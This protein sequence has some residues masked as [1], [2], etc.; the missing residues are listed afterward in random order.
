MNKLKIFLLTII[1]TS[2]AV[3]PQ[4]SWID[5]PKEQWPAIAMINNVEYKNGE[6]YIHSSFEYAGTGFLVDTGSDTLAVTAKH[7]LWIAKTKSMNSVDLQGNLKKWIM[8]PKGN[9]KDSVVITKLINTDSSEILNGPKSTITERD[10]IVF[11]TGYISPKIKPLKPRY[12]EVNIGESV[13]YF[14]CPYK[15]KKCVIKE[16]EIL[17]IEGSRIVF[18]SKAEANIAGASGSPIVDQNGLLIGIVGGSAT[19]KSTGANAIY[20]TSTKYLKKILTKEQPLNV[21]LISVG[22]V[23]KKVILQEGLDAGIQ[24]FNI[25]KK[26]KDNYFI[27]NFSPEKINALADEFIENEDYDTG[28]G[29][30][31]LSIKELSLTGTYTKLGNAY[32]KVDKKNKA[33]DAFKTAIKLWPDNEEAINRLKRLDEN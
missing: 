24:K 27:Y 4:E 11:E 23:I 12:N 14:G 33:I 2:C 8:H 3:N 26:N 25:L 29:L 17:E 32:L 9:P 28:I 18:S 19:A 22:N 20:G 30:Y 15:D 6:S 5:Q 10:W 7:I 21:P 1:F 31:E 16:G 13:Y